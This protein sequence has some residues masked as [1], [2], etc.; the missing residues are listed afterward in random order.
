MDHHYVVAIAKTAVQ[1]QKNCS[2]NYHFDGWQNSFFSHI[3]ALSANSYVCLIWNIWNENNTYKLYFQC[4]SV[5]ENIRYF[6]TT[7]LKQLHCSS[8]LS[9]CF[10]PQICECKICLTQVWGHWVHVYDRP[11]N[12]TVAHHVLS[13]LGSLWTLV[14]VHRLASVICLLLIY[15]ILF[16]C[17]LCD[18]WFKKLM[19]NLKW[20][21]QN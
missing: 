9:M 20:T 7:I 15:G 5:T 19:Y 1:N 10:S 13:S 6:D 14:V 3:T 21:I 16:Q 17:S 8:Y 12:T 18:A 4:V 11:H 2:K